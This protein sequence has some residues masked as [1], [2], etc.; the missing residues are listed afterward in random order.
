MPLTS[1]LCRAQRARQ[2]AAQ[3]YEPGN[4]ARSLKQV[5]RH[6]ARPEMGICYRTFL[7][8]VRTCH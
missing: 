6:Y 8:Y 5:W 7:R 4:Q 3:H 1:T 2:I